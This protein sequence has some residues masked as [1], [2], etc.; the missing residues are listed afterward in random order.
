MEWEEVA[1]GSVWELPDLADFEDAL[2]EGSRNLLQLALSVPVGDDVAQQLEDLLR[3][4][5]VEG[6]QVTTSSPQLNIYF[7]KGSPDSAKGFPWLAV[8]VAT[9]LASLVIIALVI[10]WRLFTYIGSVAPGAIPFLALAAVGAVTIA[11][12]YLMRRKNG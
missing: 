8:I 4:A 2:E 5:G 9:V 1:A 12:I 3:S 6:V 7:K 11:G 10:A